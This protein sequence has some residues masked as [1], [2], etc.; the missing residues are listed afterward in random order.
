MSQEICTLINDTN[1]KNLCSIQ[2]TSL[3]YFNFVGQKITVK[4]C[5]FYDGDT[6]S[7]IFNFNDR[8]I[9][10]ILHRVLPGQ[11]ILCCFKV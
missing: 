6:F 11:F 9:N 3:D 7:A 5:H 4:P 2:E 10:I 1:C 8:R